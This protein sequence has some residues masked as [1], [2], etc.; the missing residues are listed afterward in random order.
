MADV[1][2]TLEFTRRRSLEGWRLARGG[3][4]DRLDRARDDVGIHHAVDEL[5]VLGDALP[6]DPFALKSH[7]LQNVHGCGIPLEHASLEPRKQALVLD[8]SHKRMSCGG[9]EALAP[10]GFAKPVPKMA[11]LTRKTVACYRANAA[12]GVPLEL[13]GQVQVATRCSG[14]GDPSLR[15]RLGVRMRK[16]VREIAPDVAIIR[17]ADQVRLVC[18]RPRAQKASSKRGR[19][20]HCE[21]AV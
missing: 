13:Y 4:N 12:D 17:V 7:L 14:N 5:T 2:S 8:V 3:C 11:G 1:R 21:C 9:G 15:I 16:R 6:Q 19:Q 10:M 20:K 18:L